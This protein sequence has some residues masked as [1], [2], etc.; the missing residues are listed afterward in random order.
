[1]RSNVTVRWFLAGSLFFAPLAQ[2]VQPP[3]QAPDDSLHGKQHE[4]FF[5]ELKLTPDQK[6]KLQALHKQMRETAK[7]FFDQMKG[8]MEK[9]KAE[10][11]KPQPSK[12]VL[13]GY[14]A[15][16]ADLHKQMAEKRADH[17]LQV[18]AILTPEQFS[19]LLSHEPPMGPEGF[20]H[21]DG[22]GKGPHHGKDKGGEPMD[23]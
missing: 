1:M 13:Y 22:K 10:L 11:L 23:D 8:I 3:A 17:L 18:K 7:P 20:R 15:Q 12:Q 19:K 9:S 2:A 14:A 4:K 21:G 6:T 5:A 16:L